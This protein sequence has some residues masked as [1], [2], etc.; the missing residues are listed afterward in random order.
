L[1]EK[2]AATSTRVTGARV[3][4]I[5]EGYEFFFVRKTKK[6]ENE[7]KKREA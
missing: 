3:L 2:R 1:S 4:T 5:S 6:E 7:R